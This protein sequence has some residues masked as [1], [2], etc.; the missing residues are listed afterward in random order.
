[1][2]DE[3]RDVHSVVVLGNDAFDVWHQVVPR[4]GVEWRRSPHLSRRGLNRRKGEHQAAESAARVRAREA[5]VWFTHR[6]A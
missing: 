4:P 3:L 2:L 5:F 6:V 1:V